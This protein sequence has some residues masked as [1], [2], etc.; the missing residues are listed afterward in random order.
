MPPL[1]TAWARHAAITTDLA[2]PARE[3][4]F[5]AADAA[6]MPE[7]LTDATRV[8]WI[9]VGYGVSASGVLHRWNSVL[10]GQIYGFEYGSV[11]S[12]SQRG[13]SWMPT[14]ADG[15]PTNQGA[16]REL[17]SKTWGPGAGAPLHACLQLAIVVLC[18]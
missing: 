17:V 7:K 6:L 3:A 14:D 12:S 2:V 9:G 4:R 16:E 10:L 1:H 8:V 15:M 5:D 13:G 11:L 18:V